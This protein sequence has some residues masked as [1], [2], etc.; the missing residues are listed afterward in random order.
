MSEDPKE[1][2]EQDE[3]KQTQTWVVYALLLPSV[4]LARLFKIP[5]RDMGDLLQMAYYHELKRQGLKMRQ[6]SDQLG[7]SMRKVAL[8]SKRLKHNFAADEDKHGLPRRLEFALWSGALSEARLQQAFPDAEPG[9]VRAALELLMRDGRVKENRGRTVTYEVNRSQFR[10]VQGAWL[11]RVDGLN[12]LLENLSAAVFGRFFDGSDEAFART[13][14]LRVRREDLPK[15]RKLYEEVIWP[16]LVKM[17][18][19]AQGDDDAQPM[20][21]SI[22]WAPYEY[23]KTRRAENNGRQEEEE[24]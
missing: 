20:D 11:A 5:L 4:R 13:L 15:M 22:V 16:E 17:D 18:E 1:S 6:I 8:L 19:A 9:Q 24:S 12:N 7:V 23:F 2:P 10:L 21:V 3:R 14:S